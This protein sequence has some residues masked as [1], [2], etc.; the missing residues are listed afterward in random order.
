MNIKARSFPGVDIGSYHDLVVMTF[1]IL[2][3]KLKK[4]KN[5]RIKFYLDRLNDPE[6]AEAFQAKLGGQFAPLLVVDQ[7]FHNLSE[8]FNSG[9]WIPQKKC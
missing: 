9:L 4:Y 8:N 1:Y 5:I 6:V 7:N 2:R 3:K